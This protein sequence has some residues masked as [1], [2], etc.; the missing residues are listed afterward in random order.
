MCGVT[1]NYI[2]QSGIKLHE[3]EVPQYFCNILGYFPHISA[4]LHIRAK[5]VVL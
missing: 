2:N 4:Y 3:I 5:E 1:G